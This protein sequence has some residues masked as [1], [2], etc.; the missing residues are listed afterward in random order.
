MKVINTYNESELHATLK[1]LYALETGGACEAQIGGTNW[2][3]DVVA[4][5]GSVVEIQTE[6]IS[7]LAQKAA[8]LL[9]HGRAVKI[10]RPVL[11]ETTIETV[12]ADGAVLSR[13]KSPKK[14]TV[15]SVLRGLTKITPLLEDEKLTIEILYVRATETRRTTAEKAQLLNRSRRHLKNWIPGGK[16]LEEILKVQ[17]FSGAESWRRLFP[18]SLGGEFTRQELYDALFRSDFLIGDLIGGTFSG[19]NRRSAAK[20]FTLL[21]WLG[22][23]CGLIEE[24]G[25]K[26]RSV[27]FRM[28]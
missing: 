21:I 13:R 5:D 8:F 3:C 7:A 14:S 12:G 18:P 17:Q 19:T 9:E 25:K 1:K 20:W 11:F 27:L 22:K 10:V 28:K 24:C 23:K 26:G 6:N 16:R 2:I 4:A 15:Y